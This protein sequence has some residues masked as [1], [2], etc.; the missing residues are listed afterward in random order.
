MNHRESLKSF[1]KQKG[2][3]Q[4]QAGE[5]LGYTPAMISRYLNDLDWNWDF[6][7]S[8]SSNFP[9]I[10]WN[11]I[12]KGNIV[13]SNIVSEPGNIYEDKGQLIIREI[14]Q[15]LNELKSCL[16]RK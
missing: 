8:L 10:D 1:L 2:L 14:E 5:I 13:G 12:I 16:I 3:S 15:K 11:A 9:E 7:T 4:K 6:I